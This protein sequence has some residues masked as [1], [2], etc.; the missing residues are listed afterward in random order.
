MDTTGRG[1]KIGGY[2]RE[3]RNDWW[4]LQGGEYR[5][6]D[7]TGRGVKIGGYYREGR[8]DWWILQ[9]GE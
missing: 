6:V 5:L 1:V 2:Y 4:I 3:G 9:G 7:T 8:N